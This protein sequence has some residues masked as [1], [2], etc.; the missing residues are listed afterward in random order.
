[1]AGGGGIWT[2]AISYIL[3]F[4]GWFVRWDALN[5]HAAFASF[6][7]SSRH[8]VAYNQNGKKMKLPHKAD[9][10]IM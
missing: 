8:R 5:S 6:N 1:M 7:A 4:S 3:W 9:M 10:V 2:E